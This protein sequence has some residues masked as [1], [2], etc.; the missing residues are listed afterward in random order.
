MTM[1]P[2]QVPT[3]DPTSIKTTCISLWCG[4]DLLIELLENANPEPHD[5]LDVAYQ[6]S[7]EY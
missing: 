1:R 6:K 5:K 7:L 4:Q 3:L 2:N